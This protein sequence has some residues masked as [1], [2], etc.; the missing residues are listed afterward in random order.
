MR[1]FDRILFLT[2]VNTNN[3]FGSAA[4]LQYVIQSD[5]LILRPRVD[6]QN[7]FVGKLPVAPAPAAAPIASTSTAGNSTGN[8]FASPSVP[9]GRRHFTREQSIFLPA[10]GLPTANVEQAIQDQSRLEERSHAPPARPGPSRP[11]EPSFRREETQATT[12]KSKS[13][14]APAPSPAKAEPAAMVNGKR[15]IIDIDDSSDE[16]SGLPKGAN[17]PDRRVKARVEPVPPAASSSKPWFNIDDTASMSKQQRKKLR[18]QQ[19][20]EKKSEVSATPEPIRKSKK[21]KAAAAE[22]EVEVT[23]SSAAAKASR[24]KGAAGASSSATPIMNK[25]KFGPQIS[26]QHGMH[27]TGSKARKMFQTD[28]FDGYMGVNMR[29]SVFYWGKHAKLV[30]NACQEAEPD[31][32][33]AV[34]D[35]VYSETHST[36][37]VGF[38]YT[39]TSETNSTLNTQLALVK[40]DM[41]KV[42]V[43]FQVAVQTVEGIEDCLD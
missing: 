14:P 35:A 38:A 31:D 5:Q 10:L 3:S 9:T 18:K 39:S 25:I 16:E 21:A 13:A 27:G 34:H 19:E 11:A 40:T 24:A 7:W 20:Q 1:S 30:D 6:P 28:T 23:T 4:G 29:G 33:V 22:V 2:P 37:V 36:M 42:T 41:A 12:A 15:P 17:G 8:G 43:S 26:I 32:R